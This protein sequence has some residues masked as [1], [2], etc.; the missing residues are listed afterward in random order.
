MQL[1]NDDN[2]ENIIYSIEHQNRIIFRSYC[3]WLNSSKIAYEKWVG[4]S[5]E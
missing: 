2:A 5:S 4:I 1:M 3:V